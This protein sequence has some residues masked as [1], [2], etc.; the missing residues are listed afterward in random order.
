MPHVGD[1]DIHAY[2]DGALGLYPEAEARTIREHIRS[3]GDCAARLEVERDLR[4]RAE[5]ILAESGPE[6]VVVPPFE[7]V[8]AR[9]EGQTS[10]PP[11]RRPWAFSPVLAWAASLMLAMAVGWAGRGVLLPPDPVS[12]VSSPAE[13][14]PQDAEELPAGGVDGP[15]AG[16]RSESEQERAVVS[17]SSTPP[18]VSRERAANVVAGAGAAQAPQPEVAEPIA[19]RQAADVGAL[20]ADARAEDAPE[21]AEAQG[22]LEARSALVQEE[23]Q[24]AQVRPLVPVEPAAGPERENAEPSADADEG[25]TGFADAADSSTPALQSR[26]ADLAEMSGTPLAV[27]GL[28]VI[29]VGPAGPPFGEDAVRVVQRLLGGERLVLVHGTG[30]LPGDDVPLDESLDRVSGAGDALLVHRLR[31]RS[32]GW[33]LATA[34]VSA[35]SLDVLLA[36]M[37]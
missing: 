13:V 23:V 19:E 30:P 4:T 18:A 26:V 32:D 35:D 34:A 2:L 5:G 14:A 28:G 27:P 7:D 37:R 16:Q 22:R 20:R 3:C 36:A 25:A 21:P 12:P 9:A 17:P 29:S 10:D 31:T 8:L 6:A 11:R 15:V 1:G 24:P 33:T